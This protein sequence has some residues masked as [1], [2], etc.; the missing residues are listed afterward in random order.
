[1]TWISKSKDIS[2]TQET[3]HKSA[4]PAVISRAFQNKTITFTPA[5]FFGAAARCSHLHAVNPALV[6]RESAMIKALVE[7]YVDDQS[8]DFAID[9]S[10]DNFKDYIKSY[11]SGTVA[12]ALSYLAMIDDGYRWADHFENIKGGNPN[13]SRSPDFVF[14]RSGQNDVALVESKGTRSAT[15]NG[16]NATVNDGYVGQVE[17]HLGHRVGTSTAT[18]GYCI[19]A[20]LTSPTRGELNVHFT[21]VVTVPVSAPGGGAGSNAAVQRHNYATAF[22]LA[23]SETLAEQIRAGSIEDVAIPFA[24]FDW[25]GERWLTAPVGL[26]P[27]DGMGRTSVIVG[28]KPWTFTG[29]PPFWQVPMF[30]V[31]ITRAATVLR[32]LSSRQPTRAEESF[33]LT[34]I[35]EELRRDADRETSGGAAIFPDGLAV[36]IRAGIM[37][38]TQPILWLRDKQDFVPFDV[39]RIDETLGNMLF[40]SEAPSQPPPHRY[41]TND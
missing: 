33:D 18:H 10:A 39:W 19:G 1:M 37:E 25:L 32:T 41:L 16:F 30:A 15:T 31:E 5:R 28:K 34:P 7:G 4:D 36:F 22:R 21:D 27:N 13:V 12:A 26:F 35:P 38:E 24:Y 14:A 8:N 23:H 20:H 11:F 17:P 3:P 2:I 6:T 9:R 40:R 29:A